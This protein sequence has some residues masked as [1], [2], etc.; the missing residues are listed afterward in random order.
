MKNQCLYCKLYL[1]QLNC[2]NVGVFSFS[3]FPRSVEGGSRHGRIALRGWKMIFH[4]DFPRNRFRS[5]LSRSL[6]AAAACVKSLKQKSIKLNK[7]KA[8]LSL[9]IARLQALYVHIEFER[10]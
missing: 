2:I 1:N 9:S 8:K 7:T 10:K 4:A 5:V 6:Y 3:F